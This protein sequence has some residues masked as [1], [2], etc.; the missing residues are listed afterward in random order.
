MKVLIISQPKSGTYLCANILQNL[1]LT[2]TYMHLAVESYD[3]YEPDNLEDGRKYPEKYR[4]KLHIA[5]TAKLISDN[6]F[7]VTHAAEQVNLP[8]F[9]DFQ[10]IVLHRDIKKAGESYNRW[11]QESGRKR[12]EVSVIPQINTHIPN[13]FSLAFEDMLNKNTIAIDDLQVYLLGFVAFD[14]MTVIEKS[15]K[16]DSLT[17]SS[18]RS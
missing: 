6:E 10:K 11:L 5:E 15:L 4:H 7:A 1:G 18:K 13:S 2:F 3:K 14:S 12:R 17:K 8:E 9:V 16:Q